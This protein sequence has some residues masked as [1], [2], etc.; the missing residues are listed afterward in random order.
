LGGVAVHFAAAAVMVACRMSP[1]SAPQ[2]TVATVRLQN[3]YRASKIIGAAVYN[4]QNEQIGT[5][6][7]LF[8]SK[9]NTVAMVILSVGGVLG[10]GSKSVAIPMD[11][12]QIEQRDKIVMSGASKEELGR[13]PNVTYG[14]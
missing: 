1:P 6:A 5:V 12:L 10:V 11:K 14:D 7:D 9:Q 3:G 13:M 8:L 4:D 2:V